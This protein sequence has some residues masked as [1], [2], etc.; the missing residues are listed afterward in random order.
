MVPFFLS[1]GPMVYQSWSFSQ[2]QKQK[3]GLRFVDSLCCFLVSISLI[4]ALIFIIS[5]H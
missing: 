5:Y 4:S 1:F 2:K 3:N